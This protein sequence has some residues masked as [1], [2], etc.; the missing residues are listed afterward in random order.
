VFFI[1]RLAF[2][3][4]IKMEA[5]PRLDKWG[6]FLVGIGRGFLFI[7]LIIFMLVIS[8]VTYLNKSVKNSYSGGRFFKIAPAVYSG[9]WQG[10]MSKFMLKEKFNKTITEVQADFK[11]P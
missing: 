11:R 10:L 2:C 7:G 1:L 8:S 5:V 9:L 6:G 3:R 4:F